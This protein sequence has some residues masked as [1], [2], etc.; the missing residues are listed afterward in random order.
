VST[1]F[2]ATK[3]DERKRVELYDTTLRDGN[4]AI[5]V[6]FSTNDKV[7]RNWMSS[8]SVI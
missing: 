3:Q 2:H 4:Q 7:K 6:N 5:G 8:E 1:K